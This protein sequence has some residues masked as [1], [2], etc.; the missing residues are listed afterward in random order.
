[1]SRN[2]VPVLFIFYL[3]STVPLS[4]QNLDSLL[5]NKRV[6]TT[7]NIG[8]L[9]LPKID[10]KLDDEIWAL[11][12]WQGDFTQ[13]QPVGGVAGSENTYIKI[14]YDRSSLFVAI[15]CQDSE[16]E[17]I[18]DIFDRRDAFNGD[19]TGIALDSYMDKRTAF[20]FNLS[21]AGQ[22][23]DLKH[24]G[25]YQWD[26]NWNGV[27]DGATSIGDTGWIAE[28]KIPFSQIRYADKEKHVWGMHV[29]RWISR[30]FE[31]DQWQYIPVEAPAMVYLFGEL[32]GVEQIRGSRQVEFLP[33]ASAGLETIS[34]GDGGTDFRPN[35]GIDAKVGISSDYTLD[36]S[37]NPDYGQVEADPS[38]LNLTAFETFYEEKRPFFMEGNEIFDFEMN[39]DIPYYSRR[40]G[41]APD[42]PGSVGPW[43][44]SDVPGNTT[45]LGAAKLTGKSSKGLSVGLVNGL[46]AAEY[47]VATNGEGNEQEIQVAPMSNYLSSRVKKEFDE[48]NTSVGGIFT[49][50]NRI[51][52]D[53]T[54]LDLMPSSAVSGGLDL[55]HYW[56]NKN[57]Y[58]EA[59]T[60]AS[61]LSGSQ[62]AILRKQLSHIHR[63]QRPDAGYLSVDTSMEQLGGHGG[64]IK[65][66]KKGGRFNFDVLGQYRSPGLNLNE[67]GFIKQADF[68]G[69]GVGLSYEMNE[70]GDWVRNYKIEF[71]Q[72]AQWSFGGENTLNN[73][74]I[75]FTLKS[76]KN[77]TYMATYSYEFSHLDIRELRGGPV[78][79]IDG[80][81]HS[82]IHLSSN[83]AKDLS[84]NAGF[85]Y[86]TFGNGYSHEEVLHASLTW[87]PGRKINFSGRAVLNNRQYQQHYVSTIS[88]TGYN[89]YVV[90]N[91]DQNTL[92]LTF[93][94]E[95]FLSPELSL[96]YYGSPYYSVGQ[97]DWFGRVDMAESKDFSQRF[98]ELVV[99]Y[100]ESSNSYSFDHIGESLNFDNP[101]FSFMQ[102]RSNLVFRWEYKLGSTLYLVWAHDRSGWESLFNPITDITGDLFGVEGNHVFMFKL[103][104]WFSV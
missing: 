16:P 92:S 58:F 53:S 90:G 82:G 27:W 52:D 15:I 51:S 34:G 75:F 70:P 78:L 31:E 61:Q 20:E 44:I 79:R 71:S 39:G 74:G 102:F 3:L 50:V 77:W 21:A 84:G 33:Y 29:W 80:E 12:E 101:D 46:T 95:L 55:L 91:I 8:E 11:G 98:E 26:F 72:E 37:I 25:D 36:L 96:Q 43:D 4:G 54:L 67:M 68:F 18:R 35:A 14:L 19:M 85:H 59:K 24:L 40:I 41:S 47:A 104:F 94:G 32:Q 87:H 1:M 38:V 48:G 13:Q 2:L 23:M 10:G 60:I 9:P 103:N 30:N 49:L 64:V 5:N 42:Y 76:N 65:V 56:N 57:Y 100:D 66:G 6:Y 88:G 45:I 81:H 28:M 83:S 63:F 7:I 17:L 99:M 69:Q 73:A 97:Y 62:E 86:N 93:R 22:K 89:E